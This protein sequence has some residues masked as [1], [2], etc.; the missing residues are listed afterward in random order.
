MPRRGT[1][2]PRM[3]RIAAMRSSCSPATVNASPAP[4]LPPWARNEK[5]RVRMPCS[6]RSSAR[7][8][9]PPSSSASELIAWTMST[10]AVDAGSPA[11]Y[12]SN[13][14]P[15]IAARSNCS[16]VESLGGPP[17]G[18]RWPTWVE[19]P[20]TASC[21]VDHVKW[22]TTTHPASRDHLIVPHGF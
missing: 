5:R 11:T 13:R 18:I 6:A 4:S 16:R 10:A 9:N 8:T 20:G 2:H 7:R 17:G 19:T 15:S 12:A 3:T 22:M 14:R 1:D 21:L